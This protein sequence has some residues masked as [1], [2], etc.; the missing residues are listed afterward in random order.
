MLDPANYGSMIITQS[1]SITGIEG[2]GINRKAG[3]AVTINAGP[4]DV[5]NLS[6]LTLDGLKLANTGIL[7]NSGG[8]LTISD[9][10]VRNFLGTGIF[11]QPTGAAKFLIGDTLVS[12]NS[13]DGIG[14]VPQG[15]GSA[16]G[17]LDHVSM[18]KNRFGIHVDG[19]VTSGAPIDVTSVDS[20]AT[21]N[22]NGFFASGKGVI[23]L[24]HSAA[25]GNGT[26]VSVVGTVESFGD[27]DIGGNDT[28]VAGSLTTVL[29]R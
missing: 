28:D 22:R 11:L 9:C 4:N 21:N 1:I 6:H 27:N 19:R 10:T 26:G 14:V 5:V 12:D 24:A 25:T 7:L 13:S 15:T 16:Q 2:A 18:N 8:S 17:T 20:R 3:D 23:R 29:K